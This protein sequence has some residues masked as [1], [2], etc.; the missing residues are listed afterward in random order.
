MCVAYATRNSTR[1]SFA[2]T[3]KTRVSPPTQTWHYNTGRRFHRT[4]HPTSS[5]RLQPH[6]DGSC[7]PGTQPERVRENATRRPVRATL[8]RQS[9][10]LARG[11]LS[12]RPFANR[13]R[14]YCEE[15]NLPLPWGKTPSGYRRSPRNGALPP[16]R[17]GP[18]KRVRTR[19]A[20]QG[21]LYAGAVPQSC[22]SLTSDATTAATPR[23]AV[24]L[25]EGVVGRELTRVR[26]FP[27]HTGSYERDRHACLASARGRG[28]EARRTPRSDT[29]PTSRSDALRRW[30]MDR[31]EPPSH[32]C[33]Q[34]GPSISDDPTGTTGRAAAVEEETRTR[35]PVPQ[36]ADA[37]TL[38]YRLSPS[39]LGLTRFRRG[40]GEREKTRRVSR[41]KYTALE[42]R[43]DL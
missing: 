30:R 29:M 36:I 11:D 40:K 39:R 38:R 22:G 24:V 34:W 31:H 3:R 25:G 15:K 5:W 17:P 7:W 21:G 6:E 18:R 37:D 9:L 32:A 10:L 16:P 20:S 13:A 2:R 4:H 41:E 42:V 8:S 28:R 35:R 19:H 26:S 23:H 43:T 14:Q 1:D 12:F 27:L 33:P